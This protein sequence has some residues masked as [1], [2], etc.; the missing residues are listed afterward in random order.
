MASSIEIDVS[1]NIAKFKTAMDKAAME[2]QALN[3]KLDRA[4]KGVNTVMRSVGALAGVAVAGGL[5]TMA[6]QAI[7]AA[8]QVEKLSRRTGGSV[9]FLSEMRFALSQNDVSMK[10]FE[11]SLRK[12]NKSTADAA[13][14]LS[15]QKR[16]FQAL[17]ISVGEFQKLDTDKKFTVL[18]EAISKVK[19]PALRTQVAMDIMGRSG[20][21]LIT[22]MENGAAGIEAY[23]KESERLGMSL[24]E[25]QAKKAAAAN[26]AIDKLTKSMS[27][28]FQQAVLDN[29]G[30]IEKLGETFDNAKL[31]G[32]ALVEGV[33]V[34]FEHLKGGAKIAGE[35]IKLAFIGSFDL[36]LEAQATLFRK[37][38]EGMNF[39]K[40]GSGDALTGFADGL[41]NILTPL[42]DFNA[43]VA[44]IRQETDG[45]IAGV[46]AITGEMAD[47]EISLKTASKTS[48]KFESST[49]GVVGE[50]ND[51]A[52]TCDATKEELDAM[53]KA[54]RE[55]EK[56]AEEL[57]RATGT[58]L[59]K[60][61]EELNR[62][63]D[64]AELYQ[65][66]YQKALENAHQV[67]I[68]KGIPGTEEYAE[69]MK[70]L[71]FELEETGEKSTELSELWKNTM[72]SMQ[73]NLTDLFR[74]GK[75]GFDS[76]FD[77]I[78]DS[79]KDFLAAFAAQWVTSGIMGMVNGQGFSGFNF[80]NAFQGGL[81]FGG[82]GSMGGRSGGSNAP[83]GNGA[84]QMAEALGLTSQQAQHLAQGAG[85]VVN[86][87][88][89]VQ[90]YRN[91]N[92][93][94]GAI[95]AA[96]GAVDTYNAYQGLTGGAQLG[97]YVTGGLGVA[98]GAYGLYTSLENGD[99]MSAAIN[100]YQT[101]N[102]AQT[103]IGAY[104][105]GSAGLGQAS[106][107]NLAQM[108]INPALTTTGSTGGGA[109][110]TSS[111]WGSAASAAGWVA[112]AIAA[113]QLLLDGAV[114]DAGFDVWD[115]RKNDWD[116]GIEEVMKSQLSLRY[117]KLFLKSLFGGQ[118]TDS[119]GREQLGEVF[120]SL[121]SGRAQALQLTPDTTFLGGF[122]DE[123][124]FF[125][126]GLESEQADR[127]A[128]MIQERLGFS[129]V[130]EIADGILRLEDLGGSFEA[131]A[132]NII[133]NVLASIAEVKIGFTDVE[134]SI[135]KS[136]GDTF[137]DLDKGFDMLVANGMDSTKALTK[138]ISDFYGKSEEEANAW[139]ENSGFNAERLIEIFSAANG[140]VLDDVINTFGTAEGAVTDAFGAMTMAANDSAYSIMGGFENVASYAEA[141]AARA[142]NSFTVQI[143]N[144]QAAA[145]R[146][147][148]ESVALQRE[149]N[150]L[151]TENN[152]KLD[153]VATKQAQTEDFI[154]QQT[155]AAVGI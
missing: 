111:A 5:G 144:A 115:E 26:D 126:T 112:L 94:G 1:A 150:R 147:G 127:V 91:G 58:D 128:K 53:A 49:D 14:G 99:Y 140:Q 139:I 17:G 11:T 24:T 22:V 3:R 85:G 44:E 4:F 69:A 110:A 52:K 19:D 148:E 132:D 138:S 38:G 83:S 43:R 142:A 109:A 70:A 131:D 15:T 27:G 93:V 39:L 46:K 50:V 135:A 153:T 151:L 8:D 63:L 54:M 92:E 72:G 71:G 18:S 154:Q 101:Y 21:A 80:S 42:D 86:I 124:T 61:Q 81:D 6:K 23:R 125:D 149:T 89:G 104:Q 34:G 30:W 35:A 152:N 117:P 76:W 45:A 33:L 40:E 57:A 66:N 64:N 36:I 102:S 133:G 29:V 25:D 68:T 88:G 114:G 95:Q 73:D 2:G 32:I 12:I 59:L 141:A 130:R 28:A 155:A 105:A 60:S 90:N 10:E 41:S 100:A 129:D 7:N 56:A 143:G 96:S 13:A 31:F 103:L 122:N 87:Y 47:Y 55:A 77:A 136:M 65:Q 98:G 74:N 119:L 121:E 67:A 113:D 9:K 120:K 107:A 16:A 137:L 146:A 78:L 79:L 106:A 82:T 48:S 75:D 84:E 62:I 20:E 123:T 97:G 118:G 51:L 134:R 145:A 37:I 116:G 108:G